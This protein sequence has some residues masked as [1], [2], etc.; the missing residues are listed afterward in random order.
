MAMNGLQGL[1]DCLEHGHGEITV[2]EPTRT[3][4]LGCIE[5]MLDFV[6]ANPGATRPPARGM[7]PGIG[8]A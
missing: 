6:Q 2:P 5:R 7:V 1:V 4:A 3:Q 8:A